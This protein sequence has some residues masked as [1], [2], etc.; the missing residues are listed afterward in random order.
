LSLAKPV[1]AKKWRKS[2]LAGSREAGGSGVVGGR[3]GAQ[4]SHGSYGSYVFQWHCRSTRVEWGGGNAWN[5][6]SAVLRWSTRMPRHVPVV[7]RK[8]G[9]DPQNG[10]L[11]FSFVAVSLFGRLEYNPFQTPPQLQDKGLG[12]PESG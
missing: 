1:V 6:K 8:R 11:L 7:P 9:F 2:V 3:D 4:R 10:T 12:P 5:G